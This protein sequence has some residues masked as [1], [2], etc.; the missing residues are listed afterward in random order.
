MY[1]IGMKTRYYAKSP[2]DFVLSRFAM[3]ANDA[4]FYQIVVVKLRYVCINTLFPHI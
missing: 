4:I 3:R 1:S 2:H